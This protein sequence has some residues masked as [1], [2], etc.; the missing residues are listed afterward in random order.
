M[1]FVLNIVIRLNKPLHA[2]VV[3]ALFAR[4]GQP[5]S[6]APNVLGEMTNEPSQPNSKQKENE[7]L[8]A[9]YVFWE[10][11]VKDYPQ[12]RDGYLELS[13]LG[14]MLNKPEV[15]SVNLQKASLL[16]P[17][18]KTLGIYEQLAH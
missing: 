7:L 17:N 9:Q 10:S 15:V 18:G 3:T 1:L 14:Y 2:Y 6:A 11:I 12:Y 5:L 4:T 16:D 13:R 8:T